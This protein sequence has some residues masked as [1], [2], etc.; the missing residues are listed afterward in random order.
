[1]DWR[2]ALDAREKTE[3]AYLRKTIDARLAKL[4]V[5]PTRVPKV[6]TH[7]ELRQARLFPKL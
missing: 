7:E 6:G 1:M 4:G 3:R 2:E 5:K